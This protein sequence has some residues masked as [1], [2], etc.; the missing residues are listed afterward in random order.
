MLLYTSE[1]Y[2]RIVPGMN[3]ISI[4][5]FAILSRLTPEETAVL[6]SVLAREDWRK[7]AAVIAEKCFI[8]GVMNPLPDW[9]DG[10]ELSQCWFAAAYLGCSASHEHYRKRG[11][12]EN[13]WIESLTDMPIW[14]RNAQRN[15]GFIGL[16]RARE[17]T[18]M[19]YSGAVTRHGRLECNSEYFFPYEPLKN[20]D[21]EIILDTAAPVINLH[22]P[23]DGPLKLSD[24]GISMRRMAEFF[25]QYRSDFDYKGFVCSSWLL[26]RQLTDMLPES[27][28]ILNFQ[29][30]GC[31]Y[32]LQETSEPLFRIFG[33]AR[34]EDIVKPTTLQRNAAEFIKAGGKFRNEGFF[35]PR[36]DIESCGYDLDALIRK[37]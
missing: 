4:E 27:S 33:N 2:G 32:I 16:E 30:L 15:S 17:W 23:E 19:L 34:P 1:P 18:V 3:D 26:D 28:N 9:Q 12:P 35:I 6:R 22:I 29:K 24:C 31:R 11:F 13:V 20:A 25:A 21:G 7:K 10:C 8:P 37:A 5:K 14:L 36:S